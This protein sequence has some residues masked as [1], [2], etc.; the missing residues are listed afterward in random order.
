MSTVEE[1]IG[2][3]EP[4]ELDVRPIIR[5]SAVDRCRFVTWIVD[6]NKVFECHVV[7]EPDDD[8]GFVVYAARLPGVVSEGDT[9]TEALE[10]ISEALQGALR[11][12][13]D[14]PTGIIPWSEMSEELSSKAKE[15]WILVHV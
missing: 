12:Y 6:A 5:F 2:L 4:Y 8:G 14:S 13:L 1:S 11:S 9:E 7:L 10:N 15:V 3:T